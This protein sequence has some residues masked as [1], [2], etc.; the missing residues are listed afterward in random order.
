M[1]AFFSY[2][3][4]V[5]QDGYTSAD[6]KWPSYPK[7]RQL[8]DY[9]RN[10]AIISDGCILLPFTKKAHTFALFLLLQWYYDSIIFISVAIVVCVY[11]LC[12]FSSSLPWS[13]GSYTNV[14]TNN[15]K[16]Y[17]LHV[18]VRTVYV[19]YGVV[20]IVLWVPLSNQWSDL[21]CE[22]LLSLSSPTLLSSLSLSLS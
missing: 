17:K 21:N 11:E 2:S 14:H 22:D 7:L 4:T 18:H 19:Q 13:L 20:K 6:F 9:L 5:A 16:A 10:G 12:Q 1:L 3:L 8:R 15:T